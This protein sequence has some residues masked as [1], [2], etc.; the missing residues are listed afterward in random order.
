MSIFKKILDKYRRSKM[1]PHQLAESYRPFLHHLGSNVSLY[2]N[3]LGTE[4]YLISIGNDV[5]I[6]ANV[7]FV[8]HDVSVFNIARYLHR[9]ET[10]LDK[11]GCIVIE[12]NAFVGAYSTLMPNCRVGKNSIVAAGSVVTKH[13]PDNEVWGGAPA[14]YIMTTE[15]YA[16]SVVAHSDEYPWMDP[17]NMSKRVLSEDELVRQR[18]K[19]FFDNQ[20]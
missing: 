6:A 12:D 9:S 7:N 4:P 5:T 8:T 17:A 16:R 2:T 1:N 19:Y 15:E 3:N 10:S 11:V 14:K 13:I 18:Q 20:L